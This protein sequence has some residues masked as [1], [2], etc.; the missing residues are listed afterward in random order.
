[1]LGTD[2][3]SSNT[4]LYA[5]TTSAFGRLTPSSNFFLNAAQYLEFSCAVLFF[6]HGL[7]VER[8]MFVF[9]CVALDT[10]LVH[11]I[12]ITFHNLLT[13]LGLVNDYNMG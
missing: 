10:V 2:S 12:D 5:L 4:V 3:Q 11:G 8:S 13:H 7:A 9:S 1:M 6:V